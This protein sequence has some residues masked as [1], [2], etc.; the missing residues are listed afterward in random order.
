MAEEQQE[1]TPEEKLLEVIQKGEG[2]ETYGPDS[3]KDVTLGDES[4]GQPVDRAAMTVGG[5]I[6]LATVSRLLLIVAAVMLG[7]S[8]YEIYRN[9]PKPEAASKSSDIDLPDATET[10][11]L[12]SLSD[13]LDLF[14]KRRILG[15]MPTRARTTTTTVTIDPEVLKGW[16]AYARD[17][18]K[19]M[20]TSEVQRQNNAGDVER[21]RE[22]ILMDTKEKKM[23]FLTTGQTI[24]LNRQDVTVAGIDDASI[25]FVAG[26]EEVTID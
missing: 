16:R 11:V 22:A 4:D 25:D 6:R 18:L 26:E 3:A 9:L 2:A 15:K 1:L 14:A 10:L 19:L 21:V 8:G 17:N 13:T 5:P 12:A 7:L 23:H 24:V 20:G